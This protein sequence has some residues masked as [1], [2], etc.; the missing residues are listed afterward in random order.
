MDVINFSSTVLALRVAFKEDTTI[1]SG[2]YVSSNP[3]T[4]PVESQPTWHHIT[5]QLTDA[6]MT[7]VFSPSEA[8]HEL[9]G[10]AARPTGPAE[11]RIL[12]SQLPSLNGDAIA[13]GRL[14]IDNI[15]AAAAPVPEPAGGLALLLAAAVLAGRR[16]LRHRRG[17]A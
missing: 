9:L 12:S 16:A 8:F 13:N 17:S 7:P 5:F 10:S 14:G 11:V 4:L 6:A 1:T 15:R 3:I 2:G